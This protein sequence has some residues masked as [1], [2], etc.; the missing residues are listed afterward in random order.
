MEQMLIS[1]A[2]TLR[3]YSGRPAGNVAGAARLPCAGG[4]ICTPQGAA[5]GVGAGA[6]FQ[7]SSCHLET[8]VRLCQVSVCT[9]AACWDGLHCG[10][11]LSRA[12][13]EDSQ[14]SVSEED[15]SM[16]PC[17]LHLLRLGQRL[18]VGYL[19]SSSF[20]ACRL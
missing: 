20:L 18:F 17:S 2:Q 12:V 5:S 15:F 7:G 6:G 11:S 19:S 9:S 1:H 10:G 3:V 13:S 4:C 8:E 14:I 16:C